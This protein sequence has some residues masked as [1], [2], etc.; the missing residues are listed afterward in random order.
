MIHA[1]QEINV[2]LIRDKEDALKVC[3]SCFWP[4]ILI[5][6][7]LLFTINVIFAPTREST[8]LHSLRFIFLIQDHRIIFFSWSFGS[9]SRDQ[10]NLWSRDFDPGDFDDPVILILVILMIPWFWAW[11]FYDLLGE[12]LWSCDPNGRI[13]MILLS[14]QLKINPMIPGL[15]N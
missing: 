5:I 15:G 3:S 4:V 2:K 14:W 6:I 1:T 8:F 9:F 10:K 13:L 7:C 12:F 11:Q